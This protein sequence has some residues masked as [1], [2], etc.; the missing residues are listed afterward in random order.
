MFERS[1]I[2]TFGNL[3][4]VAVVTC[5]VCVYLPGTYLRHGNVGWRRQTVLRHDLD[6]VR[7]GMLDPPAG[8]V[9]FVEYP[10]VVVNEQGQGQHAG[11]RH[12]GHGEHDG[13]LERVV[14]GEDQRAH[15]DG[16]VLDGLLVEPERH[17]HE[18]RQRY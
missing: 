17:G 5:C 12:H 2:R 16:V 18:H 14:F 8:L 4:V 6:S 7:G 3:I 15:V 13:Q 9:E 11:Q 1:G 10:L